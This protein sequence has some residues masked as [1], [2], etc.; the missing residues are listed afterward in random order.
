MFIPLLPSSLVSSS[1]DTLEGEEIKIV[2]LIEPTALEELE[3][4]GS[5]SRQGECVHSELHVCV[6]FFPRFR[7]V[8]EDVNVSV[9]NLQEIDMAGNDVAFEIEIEPALPVVAEIFSGKEHRNFHGD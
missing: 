3:R 7:L 2:F 4:E 9:A 1:V 8:I 6:S 5:S